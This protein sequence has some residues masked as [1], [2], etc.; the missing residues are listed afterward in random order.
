MR[1][2]SPARAVLAIS[3]VETVIWEAISLA[4]LE[5]FSPAA[6]TISQLCSASLL[7]PAAKSTLASMRAA[8][9]A[10]SSARSDRRTPLREDRS[11]TV[12]VSRSMLSAALRK[13]STFSVSARSCCSSRSAP[14]RA[15]CCI[16]SR[17]TAAARATPPI[18]SRRADSRGGTSRSKSPAARRAMMRES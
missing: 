13:A 12:V 4:E 17:N 10:S 18:S 5:S 7:A 1:A 6:A 16:A 8:E 11:A 9:A 3:A 15:F 2:C 14:A